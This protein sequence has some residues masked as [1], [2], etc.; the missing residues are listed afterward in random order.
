MWLI[1]FVNEQAWVDFR[2]AELTSLLFLLGKS[3]TYSHALL[4]PHITYEPH[5]NCTFTYL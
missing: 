3:N 1:Q 4:T 5:F 2:E